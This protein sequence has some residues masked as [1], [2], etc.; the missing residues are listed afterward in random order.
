[1]ANLDT[2]VVASAN[3]VPGVVEPVPWPGDGGASW[4]LPLAPLLRELAGVVGAGSW[5]DVREP[6][7]SD[8]PLILLPSDWRPEHSPA[9]RVMG[10]AEAIAWQGHDAW[11]LFLARTSPAPLRDPAAV[12]GRWCRLADLLCLDLVVE[13]RRPPA[14]AGLDWTVRFEVPGGLVPDRPTRCAES[15]VEAVLTTSDRDVFYGL[16]ERGRSAPAHH[17]AAGYQPRTTPPVID[18]DQLERQVLAD[19]VDVGTGAP[20]AGG[21]AIWRDGRWWHT[22]LRV[23]GTSEQLAEWSTGQ[24]ISRR[25]AMLRRGWEPPAPSWQ[26]SPIPYV[27]CPDCDPHSRL[28]RC[29]CQIMTGHVDPGCSR[30]AGSGWAPSPLR[31]HTCRGSRRLYRD[32]TITITDL[33]GRVAHLTWHADGTGWQTGT[34]VWQTGDRGPDAIPTGPAGEEVWR[35]GEWVPAPHVATHPG[36]KPLHQL[37]DHFR[38]APWADTFAVRPEDLVELDGGSPLSHGLRDGLVTL[39][40]PGADPLTEYVS[41]AARGRPA[42]RLFVLARRPDMPPL[43]DLIRLVLGLRL[44]VTITLTD[45][46]PNTGDPRLVQGESWDVT[47]SRLD[48]PPA[49]ADPPTR[50]TPQAAIAFC[51]DYLELAITGNIPDD[52][53]TPIPVPQTPNPI[54]V[55]D[56]IPFLRRLARHHAGQPVA[57]HYTATT[58]Q[59]WLRDREHVHRLATA[60]TLPAALGALG[61]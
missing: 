2:G 51:L 14:G 5:T 18:L 10:E 54:Q 55:D 45:H 11:R 22:S 61:L 60:P 58:C 48:Q 44:A 41:T 35:S 42:A 32:A 6:H 28:Q 19:C 38:L 47:I 52:P 57:V 59:V 4:Y 8:G 27:D 20:T 13:A 26:G 1:M 43:A 36:G 53:T 56:P 50:P 3:V 49:P 25:T 29:D 31:C 12:L 23:A 46:T 24:I 40:W 30:C 33:A 15:L 16:E 39:H 21:Q 7:S 34:R 17:L 37:P 9:E